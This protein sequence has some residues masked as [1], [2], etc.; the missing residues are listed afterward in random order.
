MNLQIGPTTPL[1]A[2]ATVSH[3]PVSTLLGPV[4]QVGPSVS[5]E[6]RLND[7][8]GQ[9]NSNGS[10][11]S[12]VTSVFDLADPRKNYQTVAGV[13]KGDDL[14]WLEE[15]KS[16]GLLDQKDSQGRTLLDSLTTL[17]TAKLGN[18]LKNGDVV[19]QVLK[20]LDNT[21]NI[22]QGGRNTCGPTSASI[23]LAQTKP[24]EYGRLIKDLAVYGE[25]KLPCVDDKIKVKPDAFQEEDDSRRTVTGRLLQPAL[26]EYG[27]GDAGYNNQNERHSRQIVIPGRDIKIPGLTPRE[28]QRVWNGLFGTKPQLLGGDPVVDGTNM[29]TTNPIQVVTNML[30]PDRIAKGINHLIPMLTPGSKP[31]YTDAQNAVKEGRLPG[32]ALIDVDVDQNGMPADGFHWVLVKEVKDGKV[33]FEDPNRFKAATIGTGKGMHNRPSG[34]QVDDNTGLA[35]LPVESFNG[36]LWSMLTPEPEKF[37][38]TPDLLREIG[39][40]RNPI[41]NTGHRQP[42]MR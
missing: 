24:A 27:N 28:M 34:Y 31:N 8:M 22:Y 25:A 41:D 2:S 21:V 7:W 17:S 33:Y 13:L 40:A 6:R 37:Q 4:R 3:D 11:L 5:P 15:A 35:S 42:I 18:D 9:S 30:S 16:K 38:P 1:N 14:K 10:L 39:N 36:T 29:S 20:D 12:G 26:M 19:T 32:M 23:N